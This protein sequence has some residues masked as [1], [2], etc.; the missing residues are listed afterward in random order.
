MEFVIATQNK[1]KLAEMRR[2]LEPLGHTVISAK[3]AGFTQDV[4]ETGTTFGRKCGAES[5]GSSPGGGKT[6]DCR[7][8]P[9]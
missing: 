7:R 3:E 4:A 9:A 2:I 8:I 1:G 6:G 5:Y